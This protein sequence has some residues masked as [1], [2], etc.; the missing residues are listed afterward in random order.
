MITEIHFIKL[1]H[2]F[3]PNGL[4]MGILACIHSKPPSLIA[5]PDW[6]LSDYGTQ[7]PRP[8]FFHDYSAQVVAACC[9]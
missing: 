6:K 1:S 5:P 3:S 7:D 2:G 9:I 8:A 4:K